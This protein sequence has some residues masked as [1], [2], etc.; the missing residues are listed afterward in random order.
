MILYEDESLLVVNKPAGMVVHPTYKNV[1]GTL[2]DEL[3]SLSSNWADGDNASI[4]GRLDKDTSGIVIVAKRSSI[5]AALQQ[6]LKSP[7]AEKIY[8]AVVAGTVAEPSG[9]IT[10]PLRI[11]PADRRRVMVAADGSACETRFERMEA[12][13]GRTLLHCRLITGRRHQ[14]R[15]HLAASG[16]PVVGDRIYGRPLEGFPRHAL[17]SWRVAFVHPVTGVRIAIESPIPVDIPR[18]LAPPAE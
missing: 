8:V 16:W 5:H 9:T 17:H 11:D 1:G 18:L 3:R 7:A 13:Y 14:A 4:V 10:L 2:L 12:A 6:N 15:V